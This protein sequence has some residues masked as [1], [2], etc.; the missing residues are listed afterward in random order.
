MSQ[1]SSLDS[2]P[3]HSTWI[4]TLVKLNAAMI[5]VFI[6]TRFIGILNPGLMFTCFGVQTSFGAGPVDC[7]SRQPRHMLQWLTLNL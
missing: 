1:L 2:N 7:L 4:Q 6:C 5:I 3:N